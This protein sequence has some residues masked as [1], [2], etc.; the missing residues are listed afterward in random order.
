MSE[1]Y[2][3]CSRYVW[4]LMRYFVLIC[5]LCMPSKLFMLSRLKLDMSGEKSSVKVDEYLKKFV[6][7]WQGLLQTKTGGYISQGKAVAIACAL[8][9]LIVDKLPQEELPELIERVLDIAKKKEGRELEKELTSLM[10][11]SI[12]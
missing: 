7:R 5:I 9:Y 10:D 2:E 12:T 3:T 4:R 11:F 1:E 6:V 8:S